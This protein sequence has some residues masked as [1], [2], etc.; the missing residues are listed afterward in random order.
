MQ[1]DVLVPVRDNDGVPFTDTDFAA[2][3]DFLLDLAGGF[4]RRGDVD[5]AWRSPAGVVMRDRSRAYALTLP[6]DAATQRMA[7]L[8]AYIRS[9]FRQEAAFVEQTPTLATAF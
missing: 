7:R 8:D 3:E 6:Q 1:V 4:T 5:G 2:F 9:H